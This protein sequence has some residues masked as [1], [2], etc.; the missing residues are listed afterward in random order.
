M[1]VLT[2]PVSVCGIDTRFIL[3]TGA[4]LNLISD[5]L[6]ARVGCTPG[7][8]THTAPRMSGQPLTIPLGTL[9][10][11]QLG[12]HSAQDLTVGIFGLPAL[13]GFEGIGGM[14]SLSYFRSVPVTI[15][16]QAGLVVIEDQA[17][18]APRLG[19]G[20][21]VEVQVACDGAATDLMLDVDLPDGR[22]ITVEV[23]TGSDTLILDESLA[24]A[25]GVDLLDSSTTKVESKDE[26]GHEFVRYFATMRG[27]ISV[28]GSPKVRVADPDVMFQKI[29]YD[30]LVGDRFLRHFTTTYD[31][32]NSRMIF[33]VP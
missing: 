31:L 32:V 21:P 26:T 3:D 2:V 8:S 17:S 5:E 30:G 18:L 15:D 13:A 9:G 10:S 29:I 14:L 33:A 19:A 7:G 24:T 1:H 23:D 25:A 27:D 20:T 6:A 28:T 11:L 22:A 12:A 4:G 16:Y